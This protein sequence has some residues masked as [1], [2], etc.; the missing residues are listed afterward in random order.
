MLTIDLGRLAYGDAEERAFTLVRDALE[1]ALD[2]DGL[3]P[4]FRG[5]LAG[6]HEDAGRC[7]GIELL[8]EPATEAS[9]RLGAKIAASIA[10]PPSART[11]HGARRYPRA[12][13]RLAN[14]PRVARGRSD[15][16]GRARA[17]RR[18]GPAGRGGHWICRLRAIR[19]A[20][21]RLAT[22]RAR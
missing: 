18:R 11:R 3:A 5:I 12:G 9:E 2:V 22:E 16:C 8:R 20:V 6:M 4:E 1:A 14:L 10:G 17:A 19:E 21:E 15:H 13:P 7:I